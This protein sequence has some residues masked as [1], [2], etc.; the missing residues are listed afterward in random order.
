[1]KI[2]EQKSVQNNFKATVL[3]QKLGIVIIVLEIFPLSCTSDFFYNPFVLQQE[4]RGDQCQ[5]P[6]FFGNK[7]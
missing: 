2:L 6:E 5:L 1:M 7:L 3:F 4:T